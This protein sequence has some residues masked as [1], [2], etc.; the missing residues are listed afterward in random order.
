MGRRTLFL[1]TPKFVPHSAAYRKLSDSVQ[2]YTIYKDYESNLSLLLV[3]DIPRLIATR[4][5]VGRET[6]AEAFTK[7]IE[8]DYWSQG[9][10]LIQANHHDA[11]SEH[12]VSSEDQARSE[13]TTCMGL[14]INT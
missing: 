8:S 1:S 10:T 14:L 9:S 11:N 12:G 7:H 13:L 6:V 5:Y 4:A 3:N 2:T